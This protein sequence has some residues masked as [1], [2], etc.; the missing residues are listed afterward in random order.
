MEM[1]EHQMVSPVEVSQLKPRKKK[2]LNQ[3]TATI[4]KKG[5]VFRGKETLQPPLKARKLSKKVV[6]DGASPP[7][8]QTDVS[9]PDSIPDAS[10]SSAEYRTLRHKYLLLEEESLTVDA[11]LSKAEG[12]AKTLEDEKFALL[13]QLVILEGL[14]DPSEL[15]SRGQ[16]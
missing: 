1:Q 13:D 6:N 14:M 8:R 3:V 11:Q 4:Q 10:I 2:P 7:S 16:L 15:K 5:E 9:T 12:E